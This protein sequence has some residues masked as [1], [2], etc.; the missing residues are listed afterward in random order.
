MAEKKEKKEEKSNK[1]R[2]YNKHE[3]YKIGEM[4]NFAEYGLGKVIEIGK[5]DDPKPVEKIVVK[6]ENSKFETKKFIKNY[7]KDKKINN[8]LKN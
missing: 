6:F 2:E 8:P 1:I 7:V 4:I 3:D 5:T